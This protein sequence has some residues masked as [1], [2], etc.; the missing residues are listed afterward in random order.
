MVLP[1][2]D[3]GAPLRVRNGKDSPC[4]YGCVALYSSFSS[5]PGAD[6]DNSAILKDATECVLSCQKKAP[7]VEWPGIA[8]SH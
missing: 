8:E 5:T 2:L 1:G 7:S 3:G 4:V 6:V